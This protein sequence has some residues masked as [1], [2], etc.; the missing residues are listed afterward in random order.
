MGL[1]PIL[2]TRFGSSPNN[3]PNM[4]RNELIAHMGLLI[5]KSSIRFDY[6]R[7][8]SKRCKEQRALVVNIVRWRVGIRTKSETPMVE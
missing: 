4:M 8:R 5:G 2:T 1:N 7:R 6:P 3:V